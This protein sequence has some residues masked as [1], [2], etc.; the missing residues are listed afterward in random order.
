MVPS[1]VVT[2]RRATY[3]DQRGPPQAGQ[4]RASVGSSRVRSDGGRA[5]RLAMAILLEV[6]P[7]QGVTDIVPDYQG[8]FAA[9]VFFQTSSAV[10][11]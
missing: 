6:E 5:L 10:G 1:R 7:A 2:A 11:R 8:N 9:L 4:V 3:A